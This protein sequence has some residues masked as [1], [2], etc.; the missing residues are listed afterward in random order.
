MDHDKHRITQNRNCYLFRYYFLRTF[1]SRLHVNLLFS[2]MLLLT[3]IY[4]ERIVDIRIIDIT[5]IKYYVYQIQAHFSSQLPSCLLAIGNL[6]V[7]FYSLRVSM[8][9]TN[10]AT[11]STIRISRIVAISMSEVILRYTYTCTHYR[12]HRHIIVF[13]ISSLV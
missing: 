2:G 6:L 8:I 13:T 12:K 10:P 9:P 1:M 7:Q 5:R 4:T 11:G 3:G